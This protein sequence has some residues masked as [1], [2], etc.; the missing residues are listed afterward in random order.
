MLTFLFW[1][2]GGKDLTPVVANLAR[3]HD[4]DLLMLAECE[5]P[6]QALLGA[7]NA[8]NPTPFAEPDGQS[9]CDRIVIYPRFDPSF[10]KRKKEGPRHTGR[11]LTLP[12]RGELLLFVVHFPSKMHRSEESQALNLVS[13]SQEVRLAEQEVRHRRTVIVGDLNMNPFETGIVGAEGLNAVMTREIARRET[14]RVDGVDHPF[15]YN[16]MWGHFGDRDH[17]QHPPGS[18]AH[19]PPGTCYYPSA[20]SRWY[21]WNI[22]DQ[23]L[24]RPELLPLFRN[25]DLKILTTD[26][27]TALLDRHGHPDRNTAS[28]HLPLLFRLAI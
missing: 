25:E 15:F 1:N 13:F 11:L 19:D 20:E 5:I 23:V 17:E 24:L 8:K 18:P 6:S 3:R 9:L 4:V 26:G 28:D 27:A 10:L 2:L 22:F 14:R 16:P 12:G 7:L 21:F